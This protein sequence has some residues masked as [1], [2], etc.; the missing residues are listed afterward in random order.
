MSRINRVALSTLAVIVFV[1]GVA[2]GSVITTAPT[3]VQGQDLTDNQSDLLKRIYQQ[4]IGSVVSID[5]RIPANSTNLEILPNTPNDPN[6]PQP[7]ARAAGSGFVYSTDGYIVTNAHVVQDALRISVNFS[8]GITLP[9]TVVG[10]DSDSDVAVLKV[11]STKVKLQPLN[12]G[13]SDKLII[14]ER[15]IAIGN[16]FGLSGSMTTGIVSAL[17]RRLTARPSGNAVYS[18]PQVIQTDAAV[19]PGNSGGPLL[20]NKAEVIGVTT[21]IE[22]QVRQSSGVSFAI[23]SNLVKHVADILIKNGKISHSYLGISGSS[24]TVDTK[25][26]M[27]L[28]PGFKGALVDEVTPGGPADQAGLQ[29]STQKKTLDGDT[30]PTTYGGDI[31]VAIDDIPVNYFEDLLG[32][33]FVKTVPGQTVKLTV[34]RNGEKVDL[35]VK[36]G[37]RPTK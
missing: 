30:Q 12:I 11:D 31:I 26:L 35:Q 9:A 36:L 19:N 21:A 16:P 24:L 3:R 17:N 2:F 14:G 15:A 34:Y 22:S 37:A 1:M 18:I 23:S 8:D 32:Y 33:L 6:A 28:D 13:D 29:A 10:A 27:K 25:D 20:N 5:V 7:Q 4:V